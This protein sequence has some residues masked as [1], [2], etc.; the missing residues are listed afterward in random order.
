M[1]GRTRWVRRIALGASAGP[2]GTERKARLEMNGFWWAVLAG[3]VAGSLGAAVT[4]LAWAGPWTRRARPEVPEPAPAAPQERTAPPRGFGEPGHVDGWVRDLHRCEQAVA[5]ARRAVESVSS[6]RAR[7]A[8]L[9][10]VRRMDAE[11]PSVQALVEVGRGSDLDPRSADRR[12]Q[13]V[14]R[15][16]RDQVAEAAARFASI[17]EDVLHVVVDLVAAPDLPRV[18]HEVAVLRDRFPLLHP[19]SEVFA[20]EDAPPP[21][22]AAP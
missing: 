21:A 13:E 17:T 5:R 16:V 14:L 18:H 15:R 2:T 22:L 11:L 4:L 3:T 8:L 7:E 19:M 1:P 20:R 12:D 10:V 9:V 6:A